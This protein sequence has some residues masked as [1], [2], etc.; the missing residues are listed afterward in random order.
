M[1][2]RT[3][4]CRK[5]KYWQTSGC[6]NK[7]LLKTADFYFYHLEKFC[8]LPMY[9]DDINDNM[10]TSFSSTN[11]LARSA[12]VFSYQHSGPRSITID[13]KLHRDIMDG[14]NTGVSNLKKSTGGD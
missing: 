4:P 13:L 9:P 3:A 12:P 14:L 10:D 7:T 2:G 8:V 5:I 11:A 6:R 1:K